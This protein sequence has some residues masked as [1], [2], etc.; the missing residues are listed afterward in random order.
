M[1]QGL[2]GAT[3]GS[4]APYFALGHLL[5]ESVEAFQKP[6]APHAQAIMGDIPNYSNICEVKP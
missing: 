3:L 4:P 6:F 5:F 2:G 1:K